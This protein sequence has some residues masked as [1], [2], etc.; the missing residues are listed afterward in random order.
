MRNGSVLDEKKTANDKGS[1]LLRPESLEIGVI[2]LT[3]LHQFSAEV[4]VLA[5][6][7]PDLRRLLLDRGLKGGE[8]ALD[9]DGPCLQR[10]DLL[11]VLHMSLLECVGD[12]SYTSMRLIAVGGDSR[13]APLYGRKLGLEGSEF[14]VLV[15]KDKAAGNVLLDEQVVLDLVSSSE[16]SLQCGEIHALL[17]E[18]AVLL[19]EQIVLLSVHDPAALARKSSRASSA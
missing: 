15:C 1:H 4:V 14:F 8:V 19:R 7:V 3:S 9:I 12:G 2:G 18:Q 5:D 6:D 17:R 16:L 10:K 13:D 11:A